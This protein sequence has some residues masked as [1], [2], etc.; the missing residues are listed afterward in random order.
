MNCRI[1][2]TNEINWSSGLQ[3]TGPLAQNSTLLAK[4][5]L[6]SPYVVGYFAI[7]HESAD[8]L[9]KIYCQYILWPI[10]CY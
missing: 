1:P 6:N 9:A 2:E 4:I 3:W 8:K 7:L 5:V 10:N